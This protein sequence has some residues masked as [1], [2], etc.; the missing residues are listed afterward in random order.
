MASHEASKDKESFLESARSARIE[1]YKD[2]VSSVK[3]QVSIEF[4]ITRWV[5]LDQFIP[6]S[7]SRIFGSN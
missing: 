4:F 7:C 2:T 1:R 3:I 5:K 6:G